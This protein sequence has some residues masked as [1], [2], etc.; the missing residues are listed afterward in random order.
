MARTARE[1][2]QTYL[3]SVNPETPLLEVHRLFVD[4]EI[5]GAPVVDE[6]GRLLGV[7][8]SVDLLRAVEEEHDA[9]SAEA[10]YLRDL[11]ESSGPDW[12]EESDTFRDRL[13]ERTVADAMTRGGITVTP[14]TPI[15][16]VAAT[17]RKHRIHRVFV[18]EGEQL[19][20]VISTFD[21]VAL[22][23]KG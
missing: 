13:G 11:L 6:T 3:I 23:E 21:L 2:M 20:G 22:L 18:V 14:E 5:N 4:E 1:V 9:A 16:Q 7:I 19:C 12:Q 8:S 17:L 15:A 10:S